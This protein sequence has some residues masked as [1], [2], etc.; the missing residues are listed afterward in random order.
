[1]AIYPCR[2]RKY[3]KTA[4]ISQRELAFLIGLASQG[5]MSEIESG[6]KCPSLRTALACSATL[7]ASLRDLFPRLS[8]QVERD[9]LARA[10][11][12]NSELQEPENRTI[13]KASV[14]ALIGRLAGA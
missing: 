7:R 12:L 4:H 5:V 10:R 13:A 6:V 11:K 3:R 1:M 14:A 8:N 2:I 9:V